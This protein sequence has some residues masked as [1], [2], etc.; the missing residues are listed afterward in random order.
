MPSVTIEDT[1]LI[2]L[3]RNETGFDVK[4]IVNKKINDKGELEVF[5]RC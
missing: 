5:W 1:D 3:I 4:T 2:K